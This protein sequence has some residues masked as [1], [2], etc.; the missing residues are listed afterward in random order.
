[1]KRALLLLWFPLAVWGAS[2]T[3]D[4][5]TGTL[6]SDGLVYVGGCPDETETYY[7]DSV[8]GS[9]SA[10]GL[11]PSAAWRNLSKINGITR[12]GADVCLMD[13]SEWQLTS[14]LTITHRGTE[15]DPAKIKGCYVNSGTPVEYQG[16]TGVGRGAKPQ[17]IGTITASCVANRNCTT[18]VNSGSLLHFSNTDFRLQ[19]VSIFGAPGIGVTVGNTTNSTTINVRRAVIQDVDFSHIGKQGLVIT[20]G[21]QE[22]AVKRISLTMASQCQEHAPSICPIWGS[23]MTISMVPQYSRILVE[24]SDC[25]NTA[26]ECYVFTGNVGIN[27]SHAVF[28]GNRG[29]DS[30]S[31]TFYADMAR[32]IV[33]ESNISAGP[34]SAFSARRP[35]ASPPFGGGVRSSVEI[36]GQSNERVLVRNHL[37]MNSEDYGAASVVFPTPAAQGRTTAMRVISSTIVSTDGPQ[38][39]QIGRNNNQFHFRSSIAYSQ[40]LGAG[41]KCNWGTALSGDFS[42]GRNLWNVAPSDSRCRGTGDKTGDPQF[43]TAYS[44]FDNFTYLSPPTFA[45]VVPAATSPAKGAG[46]AS[47]VTATC[48]NDIANWGD[49]IFTMMEY[50]YTPTK[51]EWVLC[52]PRDALGNPRSPTAPTM[53]AME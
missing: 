12:I 23:A 19:D 29:F 16:G 32:D 39:L 51:A 4:T 24:D 48:I 2:V 8:S 20:R 17:V 15:S 36:L 6:C 35:T 11:T 13:D 38:E 30:H 45:D 27:S 52:S 41:A 21:T 3:D 7:I 44:A 34:S 37:S 40:A 42:F 49:W 9:D 26:G 46:D 25:Y 43:A 31:T 33:F 28:R 14:Q 10:N 50:P 18:W 53:G 1:M 47:L 22:A 5:L